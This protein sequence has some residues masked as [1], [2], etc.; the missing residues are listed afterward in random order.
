MSSRRL[1]M[2][3]VWAIASSL[4]ACTG[5][6]T[7]VECLRYEAGYLGPDNQFKL[8]VPMDTIPVLDASPDRLTLAVSVLASPSGQP[9]RATLIH[10]IDG[11]EVGKWRL[12]LPPPNGISARCVIASSM[13]NSNCG[14]R[15]TDLPLRPGGRYHLKSDSELLLE[16]GLSFHVC[17]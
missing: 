7:T 3:L 13:E 5:T 6:G 8:V 4:M 15:L 12:R 10:E 2:G 17:Q 14:V 1:R 9:I 16:A 11:K